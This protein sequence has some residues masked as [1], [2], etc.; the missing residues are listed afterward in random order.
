MVQWPGGASEYWPG[1]PGAFASRAAS[2]V[3][4]A[5]AVPPPSMDTSPLLLPPLLPL[6]PPLEDDDVEPPPGSTTEAADPPQ[7]PMTHTASN[8]APT[9]IH[10]S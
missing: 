10:R 8:P 7:A 2:F 4:F 5:S 1:H 3:G 9:R 6:V